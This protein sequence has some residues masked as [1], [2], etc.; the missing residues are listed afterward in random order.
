MKNRGSIA[1]F[2]DLVLIAVQKTN[3]RVFSDRFCNMAQGMLGQLIVMVENRGSIAFLSVVIAYVASRIV[4]AAAG[5]NYNI[6]SDPF[7]LGKLVV[8]V[9]VWVVLYALIY[10]LVSRALGRRTA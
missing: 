6:F 4:F 3:A 7:D 8:D 9:G 5:F 10:S 2:I 1:F